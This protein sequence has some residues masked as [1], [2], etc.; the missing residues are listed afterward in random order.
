M[1]NQPNFS[2]LLKSAV[3]EPGQIHA[4]Y[5]HFH[6][7]SLGNQI[8]AWLQC[9]QR[10]IQ[11][12]PMAT[13]PRWQSLGRHVR[14]GEKAI[15]LCQPV[16]VRR[17]LVDAAT[18]QE[19]EIAFTRFTY[20]PCWFVLAQTEGTPYQP[21]ALPDWDSQRALAALN[22]TELPF[23]ILN[24]NIQGFARNRGV[25]VSPVAA[26]P[27]K[28]LIHEV[29]HVV[30]GHTTADM[31]TDG[32]DPPRDLREVEAEATAMLVCAALGQPGV[33]Y[34]RG[35]IQSWYQGSEIPE[36]NAQRILKAA[37]LILRAGRAVC[38]EVSTATD[39]TQT[40]GPCRCQR[41]ERPQ[42]T[43]V[44]DLPE[45]QHHTRPVAAVR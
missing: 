14:K 4:A 35:Y 13:Y 18:E 39:G 41:H 30:L 5:S 33:E 19:H 9:R 40:I 12:G 45:S 25:A 17:T 38:E 3:T 15:V 42:E 28:T 11:P 21:P 6:S 20:R 26:M 23:D 2:D 1:P 10:D 22:I 43:P 7:Y 37:D 29:A 24:G 36:R 27:F 34:S 32:A 16:T 44:R 8:L 31:Q